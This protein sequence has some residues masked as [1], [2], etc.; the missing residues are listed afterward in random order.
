MNL[1]YLYAEG[2]DRRVISIPG[3]RSYGQT[4]SLIGMDAAESHGHHA[5]ADFLHRPKSTLGERLVNKL[6][7]TLTTLIGATGGEWMKPLLVRRHLKRA[8]VLITT[9]DRVGIPLLIEMSLGLIPR[10]PI[11]YISIGLPERWTTMTPKMQ[12]WF[13]RCF[14]SCVSH[15]VCYGFEEREELTSVLT[16]DPETIHFIPFGVDPVQFSPRPPQANS[17]VSILSFGADPQRDFDLLIRIAPQ[18]EQ[19]IRII[20]TMQRKRDLEQ[21]WPRLPKNVTIQTDVGFASLPHHIQAAELVVFPLHPNSYSGATTSLL[22]CMAMGKP[23]VVSRTGAIADGYHLVHQQNVLLATPEDP[24]N[25]LEHIRLCLDAPQRAQEIGNA[26]RETIINSLTW[27]HF[28][29]NLF[30]VIARAKSSL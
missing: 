22:Q 3:S 30:E 29:S 21:R 7:N 10:R 15:V 19:N 1:F 9:S 11:V 6:L 12:R 4:Y 13:R 26:A 16:N 8:D 28:T 25:L 20:T 5:D 17:D 18:L 24:T 2:V 14:A 27:N 23:V